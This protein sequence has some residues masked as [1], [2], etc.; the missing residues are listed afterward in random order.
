[1]TYDDRLCPVC[2]SMAYMCSVR[3]ASSGDHRLPRDEVA[4]P[5]EQLPRSAV[6]LQLH[7]PVISYLASKLHSPVVI[8]YLAKKLQGP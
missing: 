5:S 3:F 1:M 2:Y 6:A 4:Q 8:D 7:S